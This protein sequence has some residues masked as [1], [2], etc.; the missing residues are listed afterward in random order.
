MENL[1]KKNTVSSKNQ[2]S[3]RVFFEGDEKGTPR[4]MFVGNSITWHRP[5]PDIGWYGDWGMA[6]TSRE[7][8]F[9]HLCMK[10][11]NEKYPNAYFCVVQ[12]ADWERGYN[13]CKMEE[14]FAEAGKF[15]PDV[16]ITRLS[17]NIQVDYLENNPLVP[18]ME[19]FH[20]FLSGE[21]EAKLIVTS[22]VFNNKLKDVY[23]K[24]YTE[25]AGVEYVYLNDY[26]KDK[27]NL[28]NEYEHEGVRIHPGDKG[29]KFIADRIMEKFNKLM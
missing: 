6:A 21:G 4:I 22:N 1:E 26:M 24:E 29:M 8:D 27:E 23:L 12:A 9:V 15:N 11:I 18:A 7:N 28:A 3:N 19:K 14:I 5:A 20:E 2:V 16:I 17:E 10:M 13:E 25:K